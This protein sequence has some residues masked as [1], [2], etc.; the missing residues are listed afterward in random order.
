MRTTKDDLNAPSS[1][2][3]RRHSVRGFY[4]TQDRSSLISLIA[5]RSCKGI[6]LRIVHEEN[7]I[8]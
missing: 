8:S 1:S 5:G 3:R 2:L 7:P 4:E 6:L